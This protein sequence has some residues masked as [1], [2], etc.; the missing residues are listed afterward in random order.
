MIPHIIL[1]IWLPW[2]ASWWTNPFHLPNQNKP[3]KNPVLRPSAR[4][5]PCPT[6][7]GRGE[8]GGNEEFRRKWDLEDRSWRWSRPLEGAAG[9]GQCWWSSRAPSRSCRRLVWLRWAATGTSSDGAEWPAVIPTGE[10]WAGVEE[11]RRLQQAARSGWVERNRGRRSLF[12]GRGV[13]VW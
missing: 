2:M 5:S 9:V 4:K 3:I 10:R 6:A 1:M 8:G 11:R 12:G 13:R 7:K